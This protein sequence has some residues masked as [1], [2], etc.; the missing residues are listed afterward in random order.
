MFATDP[1]NAKRKG[2]TPR[3]DKSVK[4]VG[5]WSFPELGAGADIVRDDWKQPGGLDSPT[6]APQNDGAALSTLPS[7]PSTPTGPL[8]QP[9]VP[10]GGSGA[11]PSNFPA[12]KPVGG[13]G[14]FQKIPNATP[15][16]GITPDP[17]PATPNMWQGFTPTNFSQSPDRSASVQPGQNSFPTSQ[18]ILDVAKSAIGSKY[19][20]G[21]AGGRTSFDPNFVGSDCSGFVAWAYYNATG[22][23]LPAFTGSIYQVTK[24][25]SKADA[26]PGDIIMWGMQNSSPEEQHTGIY[27]GGN[28]WIH[29]SSVNPDGGVQITPLWDGVEF[30][31]VPGVDAS[32][33]PQHPTFAPP[34]PASTP[35]P[36]PAQPGPQTATQ[37]PDR[38]D[39][40]RPSVTPKQWFT[41]ADKGRKILKVTWS[42]GNVTFHDQGEG[43]GDPGTVLNTGNLGSGADEFDAGE[44][45]LFGGGTLANIDDPNPWQIPAPPPPTVSANDS[46]IP[47]PAMMPQPSDTLTNP[48]RAPADARLH[49]EM[50]TTQQDTI[51]DIPFVKHPE[52]QTLQTA[53]PDSGR[54]LNQYTPPEGQ[55]VL[56]V[57]PDPNAGITPLG[58]STAGLPVN[59]LELHGDIQDRFTKAVVPQPIRDA[60]VLGGL[61]EQS[62]D[63]AWAAGGIGSATTE[64]ALRG[65]GKAIGAA[66]PAVKQAADRLVPSV[67]PIV[68]SSVDA[69]VRGMDQLSPGLGK[70]VAS[71]VPGLAQAK[72]VAA[73]GLGA[74]SGEVANL[75]TDPN[76]PNRVSKIMAAA[77]LGAAGPYVVAPI[78][79]SFLHKFNQVLAPA[80]NLPP[81]VQALVAGL[82]HGEEGARMA[83]D[84]LRM[85][86]LDVLADT[87]MGFPKQ[88]TG[89]DTANALMNFEE[90]KGFAP[91]M[92]PA[93]Q[94][95]ADDLFQLGEQTRKEGTKLGFI[96]GDVTSRHPT[97][98]AYAP[99]MYEQ[100]WTGPSGNRKAAVRKGMNPHDFYSMERDPKEPLLR[101]KA[102]NPNLTPVDSVSEPWA[103]YAGRYYSSKAKREFVRGLEK[104]GGPTVIMRNPPKGVGAGM[105]P[106]WVNGR[107]WQ[108][109]GLDQFSVSPDMATVLD[110]LYNPSGVRK[111]IGGF[112]DAVSEVKKA[113][114]APSGFHL[115][116]ELRQVFNANGKEGV[117]I[118]AKTLY[119]TVNPWAH[120]SFMLA[121][122]KGLQRAADAGVTLLRGHGAGPDIGPF[123]MGKVGGTALRAAWSGGTTGAAAYGQS[124][125]NLDPDEV[126]IQNGLKAAGM[127][128]ALGVAG[129]PLS[130]GLWNR[131]VPTMKYMSWEVLSKRYGEGPAAEF[132]N[133]V[134]GGQNLEAIARSKTVQD[135]LRLTAL[136][137]DWQ[138]GWI[139]QIGNGLRGVAAIPYAATHSRNIN[140]LRVGQTNDPLGTANAHYWQNA[141][142]TSAF[143]LE[144]MN[145]ALNGHFTNENGDGNQLKLELT[146][147]Y[148]KFGWPHVDDR[149]RPYRVYEDI[150]GP[151][152]GLVDAPLDPMKFLTSR[153]GIAPSVIG[154]AVSGKDF[155][156]KD[157]VPPGEDPLKNVALRVGSLISRMAPASGSQIVQQK[158]DPLAMQVF[159]T[160][161][162]S[163]ITHQSPIAEQLAQR[164]QALK[165]LGLTPDRQQQALDT[166]TNLLS[167]ADRQ[168]QDTLNK[169]N[170]THAQIDTELQKVQH[171]DRPTI[172]AA[173]L[174]PSIMADPAKTKEIRDV[175]QRYA[176]FGT[177]S[178]QDPADIDPAQ[179]LDM[180]NIY[181]RYWIPRQGMDTLPKASQDVLRQKELASMAQEYS[182]DPQTLLDAI[183]AKD[184]GLGQPAQVQGVNSAAIDGWVKQWSDAGNSTEDP[185]DSSAAKR[186]A[187]DQIAQQYG[188]A[189]DTVWQ[190]IKLRR[191]PASKPS[192]LE[193]SRN[194]AL[195]VLFSAHDPGQ[196]PKYRD[197]Q[198]QPMGNA[199]QWQSF[200]AQIAAIKNAH[201]RLL[202]EN[203]KLIDAKERATAYERKY[204][205]NSPDYA[206]YQRWFGIGRGMNEGQWAKYQSG[207]FPHYKDTKDPAENANRD[208]ISQQYLA[209]TPAERRVTQVKIQINGK[210]ETLSLASAI[211]HIRISVNK[212]WEKALALDTTATG[213]VPSGGTP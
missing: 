132:V 122:A 91:G 152:R 144:G 108:V 48:K 41:Y 66:A 27:L 65:A 103:M 205:M 70:A 181:N 213:P 7:A 119:H 71:K 126:A 178:S 98:K 131:A 56:P 86:I 32:A 114:F 43:S 6:P 149:G 1:I 197:E 173:A 29:D 59:P 137:P 38:G 52:Q 210:T 101:Q 5:P 33:T 99:H 129:G 200:D 130:E 123:G 24:S 58:R 151:Y 109:P 74:A 80:K 17:A 206:E 203:K 26:K 165:E 115:V 12:R 195:D 67:G 157:I 113:L 133:E 88:G 189:P 37:A 202:P 22:I 204:V 84:L 124:K 21:G 2:W 100:H 73:L 187:I 79:P 85:R 35:A 162:G 54:P 45:D 57:K 140:G 138:E 148:D 107:R 155:T 147:M 208:N 83:S 36:P 42:D 139:R 92:T 194:K 185:M 128:A 177:G 11:P 127:G 121:N 97:V 31:R 18:S 164:D 175:L 105:P 117:P 201:D 19:Q 158:G 25:I 134:F 146:G 94:S 81:N 167:I 163:R 192:D 49:P 102:Q 28:S 125:R 53:Q 150:L 116:N 60:P 159:S 23:K 182:T 16:K 93:Q 171:P 168:F 174:P 44:G 154:E 89:L 176:S 179:N 170:L 63:P 69:I 106:D 190:R 143:M 95:L 61:V 15:F 50:D 68:K 47:T 39:R 180:D 30:R 104:T 193:N 212:G 46:R 196:F 153:Q 13:A 172:E 142:V 96:S 55:P 156:G 62:L 64:T 191:L 169:K 111:Y 160:A 145:L 10:I 78:V 184:R 9:D 199:A 90:T 188:L 209:A 4:L 14:S 198:G 136:A 120:R 112:A 40:D 76:D 82:A 161:T 183:K 186:E 135:V 141:A 110:N 207:G 166:Y 72:Y 20:W 77:T 3:P 75:M 34:A 87:R 8:S 118:F 211:R 51:F